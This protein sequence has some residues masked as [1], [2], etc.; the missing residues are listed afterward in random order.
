MLR[1][2]EE[3][4]EEEEEEEDLFV[5]N[6]TIE[7]PRAPAVKPVE[8]SGNNATAAVH[9]KT[10]FTQ[11]IIICTNTRVLLGTHILPQSRARGEATF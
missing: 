4:E 2:S 1:A 5:F 6:D 8:G 9:W 11:E 10:S 7:G 3:E